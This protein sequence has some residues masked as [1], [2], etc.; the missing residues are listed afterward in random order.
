M[1]KK[2]WIILSFMIVVLILFVVTSYAYLS[3]QKNAEK[4][5][6]ISV[7]VYHSSSGRWTA[8]KE[9]VDQAA[10][11]MGAVVNFTALDE[12]DG[13]E[14][15]V[16]MIRR[17]ME[18]GSEGLVVAM[19]D[20]RVMA[21]EM[22]RISRETSVVL[23]ESGLPGDETVSCVAADA[24]QMGAEL[25]KQML[26]REEEDVPVKVMTGEEERSSLSLRLQGFQDTMKAEGRNVEEI[27]AFDE[28]ALMR[29]N[30]G[31]EPVALAVLDDREL[32]NTAILLQD[33]KK[34]IHLYGIGG[35]EKIVYALDREVIS[36]I[37]I[38][39]EFNMGYE[40]VEMLI[41]KIRKEKVEEAQK[42]DCYQITKGT[43]H[44]KEN[45]RLLYPIIQ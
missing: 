45:E 7:V 42:I 33:I 27:G 20:S 12:G 14:E 40:S 16:S 23:V 28:E 44:L 35:S 29:L 22:E 38:Q 15:Q 11:D 9:G 18:N 37:V 2:K 30:S 26:S 4:K 8:F 19:A 6:Q 36:G 17:E 21:E 32:E 43:M 5:I 13:S 39:N 41:Q 10:A 31:T 34:G 1:T 3:P 24:Y 25:A